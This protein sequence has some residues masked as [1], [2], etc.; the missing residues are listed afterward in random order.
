[1]QSDLKHECKGC[2]EAY[3]KTWKQHETIPNPR[4]GVQANLQSVISYCSSMSSK[5]PNDGKNDNEWC[6]N[7]VIDSTRLSSFFTNFLH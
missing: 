4:G 2:N 1:M 6:L 5:P 7:D 3:A